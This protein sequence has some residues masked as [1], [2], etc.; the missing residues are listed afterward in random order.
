MDLQ[1]LWVLQVQDAETPAAPFEDSAA[2][3]K[4]G[5]TYFDALEAAAH[6][7]YPNMKME[8][9]ESLPEFLNMHVSGGHFFQK[10]FP[11]IATLVF[12]SNIDRP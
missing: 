4:M 7:T 3:A 10:E 5:E 1:P 12:L 8:H 11:H 9:E 6:V 2:T